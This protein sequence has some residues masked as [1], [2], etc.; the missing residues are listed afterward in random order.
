MPRIPSCSRG[1][2]ASAYLI[3][4]IGRK[5]TLLAYSLLAALSYLGVARTVD[6]NALV[7]ILPVINFCTVGAVGAACTYLAQQYPTAIRA[8]ATAWVNVVARLALSG[9]ARW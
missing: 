8:T 2:W 9:S 3:E 1:Y 7:V 6:P 5:P 4:R